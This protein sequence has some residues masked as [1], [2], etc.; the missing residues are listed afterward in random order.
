[1]SIEYPSVTCQL[2]QLGNETNIKNI[3]IKVESVGNFHWCLFRLPHNFLNTDFF[4]MISIVLPGGL[5]T[6]SSYSFAAL[7]WAPID[8]IFTI[9]ALTFYTSNYAYN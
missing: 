2:E 1:M 4:C 8:N 5:S 6:G 3:Y 7:L 9:T